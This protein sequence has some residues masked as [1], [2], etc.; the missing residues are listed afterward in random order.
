MSKAF[1]ITIFRPVG[2]YG[3]NPHLAHS[4]WY[5]I[6]KDIKHGIDVEVAGGG[7][8]VSVEDVAHAIELARELCGSRSIICG[9]PQ[10]PV[11]TIDNTQSKV[12]GVRYA[13]MGGLRR[14]IQELINHV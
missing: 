1:D 5:N 6:A 10:Q 11:H 8:V 3:I 14:Y 9:T 7:K 12:L 2:I 4:A 13:G